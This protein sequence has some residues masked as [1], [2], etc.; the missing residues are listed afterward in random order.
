MDAHW[1]IGNIIKVLVDVAGNELGASESAASRGVG[2][3][4]VLLSP[5]QSP[6]WRMVREFAT[7]DGKL[8]A[9]AAAFSTGGHDS[10][11][12]LLLLESRLLER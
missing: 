1:A 10:L 11:Y 3:I 12:H 7:D 8:G 2:Y 9:T 5:S 4:A 6:Y